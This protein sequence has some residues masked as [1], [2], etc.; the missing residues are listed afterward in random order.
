[1]NVWLIGG[2]PPRGGHSEEVIVTDF[3]FLPLE[4]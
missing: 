2:N 4:P 3:A 1:M